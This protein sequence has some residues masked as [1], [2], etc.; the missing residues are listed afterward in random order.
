MFHHACL[1]RLRPG[2][3]AERVRAAREALGELAERLPGVLQFAVVDNFAEQSGGYRLVLIAAFAD[4]AA[5]EIYR[6][7]PE[8]RRVADELLAPIVA[9]QI[10]VE[11]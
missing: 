10:Q 1:Y 4:R 11:G 9:E 6:R 8:Q 7:D 3:P 2:I 5:F